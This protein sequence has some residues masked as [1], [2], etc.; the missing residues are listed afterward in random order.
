[1]RSVSFISSEFRRRLRE[2][3]LLTVRRGIIRRCVTAI[4]Y[5]GLIL[6][7]IKIGSSVVQPQR[8]GESISRFLGNKAIQNLG[9]A[10]L[11]QH[12]YRRYRNDLLTDR[13]VDGKLT[14][15]FVAATSVKGPH[16]LDVRAAKRA[17]SNNVSKK[18]GITIR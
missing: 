6:G 17:F 7:K 5:A 2:R 8:R 14:A 10:M 1:M 9:L 4:L 18:S 15:V 11:K 16:T 12:F 13:Q 3:W